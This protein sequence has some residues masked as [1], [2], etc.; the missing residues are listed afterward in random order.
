VGKLKFQIV[1]LKPDCHI[2]IL[3]SF[4]IGRYK[5]VYEYCKSKGIDLGKPVGLDIVVDGSVPQGTIQWLI[6]L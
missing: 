1:L 5:G 6:S 2:F 3:V 4:S